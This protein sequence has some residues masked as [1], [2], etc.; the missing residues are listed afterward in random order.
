MSITSMVVPNVFTVLMEHM[1]MFLDLLTASFALRVILA[2]IQEWHR[3][4][5]Q[6]IEHV[7]KQSVPMRNF[8]KYGTLFN[9]V[10]FEIFVVLLMN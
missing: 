5:V 7:V 2:P 9:H 6:Q 10:F 3:V 8:R 4:P 1:R